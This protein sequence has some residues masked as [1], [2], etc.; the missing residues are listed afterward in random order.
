MTVLGYNSPKQIAGRRAYYMYESIC[1]V[2]AGQEKEFWQNGVSYPRHNCVS[3]LNL[4]GKTVTYRP[5][6]NRGSR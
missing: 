2:K 4:V 5:L 3:L 6:F 1:A